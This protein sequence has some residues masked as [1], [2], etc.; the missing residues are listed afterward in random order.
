MY[1]WEVGYAVCLDLNFDLPGFTQVPTGDN[2]QLAAHVGDS[3]CSFQSERKAEVVASEEESTCPV[4]LK[5]VPLPRSTEHGKGTYA[6]SLMVLKRADGGFV[7]LHTHNVKLP[8]QLRNS[9]SNSSLNLDWFLEHMH[10]LNF[11]F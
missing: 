4:L 9:N 11:L 5:G 7:S 6:S 3:G 1:L 10:L 8:L 2:F